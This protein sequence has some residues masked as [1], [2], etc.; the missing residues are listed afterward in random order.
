M[1]L[2]FASSAFSSN[3]QSLEE[4]TAGFLI[5]SQT[6]VVCLSTDALQFGD[7]VSQSLSTLL[8]DKQ[9][10]LKM[11][12]YTRT[13]EFRDGVNGLVSGTEYKVPGFSVEYQSGNYLISSSNSS[14]NDEI[15]VPQTGVYNFKA[16]AKF[17]DN[18]NP[19]SRTAKMFLNLNRSGSV[20]KIQKTDREIALRSGDRVEH[21]SLSIDELIS[22][23]AGD[24]VSLHIIAN[25]SNSGIYRIFPNCSFSFVKL[26]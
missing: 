19:F 16:H 12:I 18:A 23:N 2:P 13:T 4:L 8:A 15:D 7:S 6:G 1:T 14:P 26:S 9:P 11:G 10:L 22:L 25:D 24:H 5:T 3:S 21:M 20:S 17:D